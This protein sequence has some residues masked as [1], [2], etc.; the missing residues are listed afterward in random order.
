MSDVDPKRP[1]GEPIRPPIVPD[2]RE[3]PPPPPINE[4]SPPPPPQ[5]S[6]PDKTKDNLAVAGGAAGIAKGAAREAVDRATASLG[7]SDDRSTPGR[8]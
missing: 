4:P 1:P 8:R 6:G 3:V 2:E 5:A 7:E